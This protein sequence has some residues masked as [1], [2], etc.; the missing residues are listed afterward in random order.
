MSEAK[1]ELDALSLQFGRARSRGPSSPISSSNES[2][3]IS[4][5]NSSSSNPHSHGNVNDSMDKFRK[6]PDNQFCADCLSPSPEWASLPLPWCGYAQIRR[7]ITWI[8]WLD[9][10]HAWWINFKWR[11]IEKRQNKDWHTIFLSSIVDRFYVRIKRRSKR[12]TFQWS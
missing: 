9:V 8:R 1:S 3:P 4:F 10:G 7:K 12:E 2:P 5:F 11:E 6:W